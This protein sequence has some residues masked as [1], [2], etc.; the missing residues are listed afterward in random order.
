MNMSLIVTEG[1]YSSID[2]DNYLCHGYY[3]IKFSSSTYTLQPDLSIYEQLISSGEI[4]CEGTYF[5]PININYR[6]CVLQKNK[7]INTVVSLSIIINGNVNVICY[8]SKDVVQMCLRY[9][10]QNNYNTLS[11]LN[12]PMK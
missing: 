10:S 2:T 4:I 7:S 1:K 5:F 8:D 12:I 6:Y 9:I 3:I 11:P